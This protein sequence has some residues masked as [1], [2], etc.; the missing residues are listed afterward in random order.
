MFLKETKTILK[1][2]NPERPIN[3]G[4]SIHDKKMVL[5]TNDKGYR[6]FGMGMTLNAKK[7]EKT[8][9]FFRMDYGPFSSNQSNPSSIIPDPSKILSLDLTEISN[10]D[11]A[12]VVLRAN[13][14]RIVTT[15][16]TRKIPSEINSFK[17][18]FNS[19]KSNFAFF[20][21]SLISLALKVP[22]FNTGLQIQGK[23][24]QI[25]NNSWKD[26]FFGVGMG[27]GKKNPVRIQFFRMDY[28]DFNHCGT[29][30]ECSDK[31]NHLVWKA[32]N[33]RFHFHVPKN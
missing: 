17:T 29:A 33:P 4:L 3:T 25:V 31:K 28:G 6:L 32:D 23:P 20:P 30:E 8:I 15:I 26:R 14:G 1:L 19:D 2:L 13:A 7:K 9:Q 10:L 22:F 12:V 5:L 18:F 24:V 11:D 21:P 16:L 27:I